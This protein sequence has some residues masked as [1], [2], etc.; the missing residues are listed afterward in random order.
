LSAP[1][2]LS[3]AAHYFASCTLERT[4]Y[5]SFRLLTQTLDQCIATSR[6]AQ[7]QGANMHPATSFAFLLTQRNHHM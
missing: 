4:G 6:H 1:H 2:D 5:S 3:A 7:S